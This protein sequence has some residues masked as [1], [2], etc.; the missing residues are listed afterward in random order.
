MYRK[1]FKKVLNFAVLE[2]AVSLRGIMSLF[3]V[4]TVII[5]IDNLCLSY[6]FLLPR[7]WGRSQ[8]WS[9]QGFG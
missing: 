8:R 2:D 6:F 9:R 4:V 5:S 3:L 1:V 7:C